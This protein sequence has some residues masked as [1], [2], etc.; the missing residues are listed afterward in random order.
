M[1]V[2]EKMR[3]LASQLKQ[4]TSAI[5]G[6][7]AEIHAKAD[8][9][10][11]ER[12][13]LLAGDITRED[14]ANVLCMD[15]DTIAD[16]Y[17]NT[18]AGQLRN[19]LTVDASHHSASTTARPARIRNVLGASTRRVLSGA[20]IGNVR[21]LSSDIYGEGNGKPFSQGAAT[22][23]FREEMK[24]GVREA[25][26]AIEPWP[27][28][29][30]KP[31]RDSLTRIMAIEAELTTLGK[32]EVELREQAQELG[33]SLPERSALFMDAPTSEAK[34]TRELLAK[35]AIAPGSAATKSD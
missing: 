16:N 20:A 33:I 21:S 29:E 28:P 14:Y 7:V 11:A 25:V 23:Y 31:L 27:F 18:M 19:G 35:Y 22:F 6:A 1:S 9:L 24:R 8:A 32:E 34:L 13:A 10:E 4:N 15:L 12:D 30:A 26:A 3:N 2:I 17:R 5:H